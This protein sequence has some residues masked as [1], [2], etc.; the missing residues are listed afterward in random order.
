MKNKRLLLFSAIIFL[1]LI[2][3]LFFRLYNLDKRIIFGW[4]QER[5]A[6]QIKDL[7]KNHH[8]TLIGPRTTNDR[9][10]FLGPYF[11]YLLTPFYYFTQLHPIATMYFIILLNLVFFITSYYLLYLLFDF[12]IA[13][14]FMSLWSI[15]FLLVNYDI[16]SWGPVLIPLG[17]LLVWVTLFNIYKTQKKIFYISLGLLL[18]F[19]INQHFQ[20]IFLA[21][22]SI[23]FFLINR[24]KAK[25]FDRKK[26]IYGLIAFASLFIP[27]LFFDL[28]HNFL[29]MKLFFGFFFQGGAGINS[30]ELFSWIPVFTNVVQPIIFI[31]NDLLAIGLYLVFLYFIF[32]LYKNK[33]GFYKN[34]YQST[35]FIWILFP[36]FFT[37]YSKRPSEYYFVF[38]YP[39][40]FIAVL[41][42]LKTVKKDFLFFPLLIIV[43]FVN[44]QALINNLKSNPFG[45]YYKNETAKLLKNRLG[46]HTRYNIGI[47]S[48]LGA[49]SGYRYL[50]G[51]YG[52][53][54]SGDTK[55]PLVEIRIPP[56]EN[57]IV[58]KGS[59]I[60]LNIPKELK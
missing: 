20:F 4:D 12:Y 15:N 44:M 41:D 58:V 45:L 23:F 1:V 21:F 5:D 13:S 43:F 17:I 42:F 57:D 16:T 29:N 40:L 39:F 54:E 34:F 6:S 26:I 35:L 46:E 50:F 30:A 53:K 36:I 11:N 55:D 7:I 19:F 14:S 52:L 27:L 31:R 38:I 2:M 49:D 9:G 28:R 33:V 60:G 48:P 3:F 22:F 8:L 25:I 37:L 51:W 18:G 47:N 10:F 32:F 56:Q 59:Y 24:K